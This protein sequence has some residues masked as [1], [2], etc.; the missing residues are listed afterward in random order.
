MADSVAANGGEP[1]TSLFAAS[2]SD[3]DRTLV[4][5]VVKQAA[6]LATDGFRIEIDK[7][8]VLTTPPP[9]IARDDER[10]PHPCSDASSRRTLA[11]RRES[12]D[13]LSWAPEAFAF[14]RSGTQASADPYAWSSYAA[15]IERCLCKSPL[16]D[17]EFPCLLLRGTRHQYRR[18]P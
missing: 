1:N 9:A 6:P 8:A 16:K 12:R 4:G 17:P 10:E 15:V 2:E 18:T 7:L 3:G 14:C 11:F 13:L 5:V